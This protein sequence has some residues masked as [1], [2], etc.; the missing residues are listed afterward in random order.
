VQKIYVG[1]RNG[2]IVSSSTVKKHVRTLQEKYAL[3]IHYKGQKVTWEQ[4]NDPENIRT[5]F[6]HIIE[7]RRLRNDHNIALADRPPFVIL[8]EHKKR[9]VRLEYYEGHDAL[10]L[11]YDIYAPKQKKRQPSYSE[12]N[13]SDESLSSSQTIGGLAENMVENITGFNVHSHSSLSKEEKQHLFTSPIVTLEEHT[14]FFKNEFALHYVTHEI[15]VERILQGYLFLCWMEH[16]LKWTQSDRI[17][18]WLDKQYSVNSLDD[19]MALIKDFFKCIQSDASQ[20]LYELTPKEE[21]AHYIAQILSNLYRPVEHYG[22]LKILFLLQRV[23]KELLQ[24]IEQKLPDIDL[25][26]FSLYIFFSL[27]GLILIRPDMGIP[28]INNQGQVQWASLPAVFPEN[29]GER[30]AIDIQEYITQNKRFNFFLL[31]QMIWGSFWLTCFPES[32]P[33]VLPLDDAYIISPY[34]WPF[35]IFHFLF[36]KNWKMTFDETNPREALRDIYVPVDVATHVFS[37]IWEMINNGLPETPLLSDIV[38]DIR[39]NTYYALYPGVSDIEWKEKSLSGLSLSIV[40]DNS[41]TQE[42]KKGRIDVS[43]QIKAQNLLFSDIDGRIDKETISQF[44]DILFPVP[45]NAPLKNIFS[46]LPPWNH[47]REYKQPDFVP[48]YVAKSLLISLEAIRM[49]TTVDNTLSNRKTDGYVRKKKGKKETTLQLSRSVSSTTVTYIPRMKYAFHTAEEVT[50]TRSSSTQGETQHKGVYRESLVTG[51]IRQ[52]PRDW[53]ASDSAR[54]EAKK[55]GIDLPKVGFTFVRPYTR[56][57]N[58]R[59]Q[60]TKYSKS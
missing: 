50:T 41:D 5:I 25:S 17:C 6:Q 43:V 37:C 49:A 18:E 8:W 16:H 60:R 23:W 15:L 38:D 55:W 11:V 9:I 52:I 47:I 36:F 33:L 10:Q 58:I 12:E 24:D 4:I 56:G 29:P 13:N 48:S 28:Y 27:M 14:Q 22:R 19:G 20:K 21:N 44:A 45:E 26:F 53:Q 31:S 35:L 7:D 54:K 32:A 2:R 59:R 39:D 34:R 42:D 30:V 3:D 51:H 46:I 40:Q 57:G 1:V